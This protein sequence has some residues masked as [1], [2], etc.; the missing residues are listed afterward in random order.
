[1]PVGA[2]RN[3][4]F[5]GARLDT[6]YVFMQLSNNERYAGTFEVSLDLT[7]S[8]YGDTGEPPAGNARLPAR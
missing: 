8:T 6:Q 4:L 7:E 3:A 1:M 2:K 5:V